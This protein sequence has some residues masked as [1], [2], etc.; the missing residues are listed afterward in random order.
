MVNQESWEILE[1]MVE[2][3]HRYGFYV[4][5]AGGS[6]KQLGNLI[7]VKVFKGSVAGCYL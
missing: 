3:V 4:Y 2:L 6:L 7:S 1:M 5:C